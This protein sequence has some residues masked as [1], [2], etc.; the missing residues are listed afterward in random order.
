MAVTTETMQRRE[1]KHTNRDGLD[2]Q[3][4]CDSAKPEV[5][6]VRPAR[7]RPSK[8]NGVSSVETSPSSEKTLKP[9][10]AKRPYDI[11]IPYKS[12]WRYP[13]LAAQIFIHAG[14]VYGLYLLLTRASLITYLWGQSF[15][16]CCDGARPYLSRDRVTNHTMLPKHPKAAIS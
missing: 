12:K 14:A 2:S 9:E 8:S 16:V 5:S 13:D 1:T 7:K 4:L 11:H 10:D 15:M 3:H 6:P